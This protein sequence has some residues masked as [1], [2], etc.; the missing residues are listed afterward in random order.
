MNKLLPLLVVASVLPACLTSPDIPITAYGPAEQIP[1][2]LVN[3]DHGP[4]PAN[5]EAVVKAWLAAKFKEPESIRYRRIS[6]PRK[7][8]IIENK[9]PFYGYSVCATVN[10]KNAFGG[11][12][13]YQTYWFLIRGEEIFRT[14]NIDADKG[15]S[16]VVNTPGNLIS[17]NHYVNC[18][19]GDA[20]GN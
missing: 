4:Y 10:A 7:E 12:A 20:N 1:V 8:Y 15:I 13:G 11:Y 17:A 18:N 6:K 2:D 5:Y 16:G 19:D 9:R 14:S 3:A